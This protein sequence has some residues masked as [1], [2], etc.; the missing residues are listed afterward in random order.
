MQRADIFDVEPDPTKAEVKLHV[1][2]DR[3]RDPAIIPQDKKWTINIY[4][5]LADEFR[6]LGQYNNA[7][8]IYTDMLKKW[9]MDPTAPDTQQATADTYDQMN[10]ATRVNTP[11]HDANAAKALE[12]RTALINY[13]GNTPWVDAN[14][15]NPEAIERAETLV[16]GGLKSA[17]ATHTNNAI[18]AL[19]EAQQSGDP[20]HIAE[21]LTRASLGIQA[22]RP[23]LG[24]LPSSRRE[25]S[26][27]LREPVLARGRATPA[28]QDRGRSFETEEG[29]AADVSGDRCGAAG[30]DRRSRFERGRQV[31]RERSTASSLT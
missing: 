22:G 5:A 31:P 16:R 4:R 28:G 20:A 29:S 11:E 19:T 8:E 2:I 7:I 14:K 10:V 18:A 1:A 13:I 15:D 26:G 9:P 23:G 24:R 30:G 3:V 25:R 17:A 21:E 27:C 12:A 6:S